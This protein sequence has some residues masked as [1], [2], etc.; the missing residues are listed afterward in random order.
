MV[1]WEVSHTHWNLAL[2]LQLAT[3]CPLLAQVPS[4]T[5]EQRDLHE[6][7]N[8]YIPLSY[9]LPFCAREVDYPSGVRFKAETAIHMRD[10]SIEEQS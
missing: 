8:A 6:A 7:F 4:V 5:V 3:V 1:V 10:R 9:H 2:E